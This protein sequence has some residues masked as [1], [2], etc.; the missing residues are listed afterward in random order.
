[1]SN[2]KFVAFG[3]SVMWGQGLLRD[4]KFCYKA[5]KEIARLNGCAFDPERDLILRAHSGAKIDDTKV[6]KEQ[7]MRQHGYA[8]PNKSA[9]DNFLN[10]G[11]GFT[12]IYGEIGETF[13]TIL[14]QVNNFDDWSQRDVDVVFLTGGGNDVNFDNIL[15]PDSD[16]YAEDN[17]LII[18]TLKHKM[19]RL[20]ELTRSK[21][22]NSLIIYTGYYPLFSR[23]SARSK[24]KSFFEWFATE[25]ES[26]G[27][28]GDYLWN[29]MLVGLNRWLKL[30]GNPIVARQR[31]YN[32]FFM[33]AYIAR[34]VIDGYNDANLI[35]SE[36]T[37]NV[38][39]SLWAPEIKPYK[40]YRSIEAMHGGYKHGQ[41]KDKAF[42]KRMQEAEKI[43]K[44]LK[45]NQY[46]ARAAAQEVMDLSKRS[47]ELAAAIAGERNAQ[48]KRQLETERAEV[49]KLLQDRVNALNSE[50]IKYGKSTFYAA[51]KFRKR[52]QY[53]KVRW[54]SFLHPNERG[55]KLFYEDIIRKYKL[56][57]KPTLRE[58]L[59]PAGGSMRSNLDPQRIPKGRLQIIRGQIGHIVLQVKADFANIINFEKRFANVIK[60]HLK[61]HTGRSFATI[62]LSAHSDQISTKTEAINASTIINSYSGYSLMN[63]HYKNYVIPVD[64]KTHFGLDSFYPDDIVSVELEGHFTNAQIFPFPHVKPVIQEFRLLVDNHEFY[65][66]SSATT[67][68]TASGTPN[69]HMMS[70]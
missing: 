22:P 3:D 68:N 21:F 47:S 29:S 55:A 34:N 19:R 41:V 42:A 31:I 13:P 60:I 28:K 45:D 39:N 65:R 44:T 37:F 59:V 5:A 52:I 56:W 40:G 15:N 7:W 16:S 18:K 1:M 32:A 69:R 36:P 33:S 20:I 9:W 61:P 53:G 27:D 6:K 8:F 46:N 2:M 10:H 49:L 70:V 24:I 35:Y 43:H 14:D 64:N 58:T 17:I 4:D 57:Q 62:P 67:W 23:N 54:V 48:R 11:K 51:S 25:Y 38:N 26:A 12:G 66:S 50:D 30:K 63:N